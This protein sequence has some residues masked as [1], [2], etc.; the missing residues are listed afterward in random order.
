MLITMPVDLVDLTHLKD[1]LSGFDKGTNSPKKTSKPPKVGFSH[2]NNPRQLMKLKFI[3]KK[4]KHE[5][6]VSDQDVEMQN[7]TSDQEQSSDKL[8]KPVPPSKVS[9]CLLLK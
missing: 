8:K 6:E 1:S 3:Q 2:S 5:E 4:P 7:P 9:F